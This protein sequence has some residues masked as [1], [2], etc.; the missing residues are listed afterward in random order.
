MSDQTLLQE[1]DQKFQEAGVVLTEE[2]RRILY[3]HF[4]GSMMDCSHDSVLHNE[5]YR[6]YTALSKSDNPAV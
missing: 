4:L 1:L 2:Q 5:A 6:A 3:L